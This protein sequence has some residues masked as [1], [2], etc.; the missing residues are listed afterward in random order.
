MEEFI[1]DG[2][3]KLQQSLS[4]SQQ[5]VDELLKPL[6]EKPGVS[7]F[8]YDRRESIDYVSRNLKRSLI[9]LQ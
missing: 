4:H 5:Q 8:N 7:E 3:F 1:T 6:T 2:Y 9:D